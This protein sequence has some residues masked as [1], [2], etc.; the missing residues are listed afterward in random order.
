MTTRALAKLVVVGI[1]PPN[2]PTATRSY[3][4]GR[5]IL[6]LKAVGRNGLVVNRHDA[7]GQCEHR[8]AAPGEHLWIDMGESA[9]Q[10]RQRDRGIGLNRYP[11]GIGGELPPALS[12]L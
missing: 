11:V 12:F 7:R 3:S 1:V 10:K 8:L 9:G 2:S 4:N 6:G 5:F